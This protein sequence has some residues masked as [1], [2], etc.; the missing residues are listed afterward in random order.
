MLKNIEKLIFHRENITATERR[1]AET[2]KKVV[3]TEFKLQKLQE[4]IQKE[5]VTWR[6]KNYWIQLRVIS[7]ASRFIK[8]NYGTRRN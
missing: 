6:L 8:I 7:H 1:I 4:E 5:K 2:S 3:E